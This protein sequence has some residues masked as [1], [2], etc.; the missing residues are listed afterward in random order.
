M[1][2]ATREAFGEALKELVIKNNDVI[3]LDADLSPATKTCYAKEARPQQDVYK[4]QALLL[5]MIFQWLVQKPLEVKVK[6]RLKRLRQ[7]MI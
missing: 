7:G 5:L 4:R 3:V 2:I 1:K 6:L